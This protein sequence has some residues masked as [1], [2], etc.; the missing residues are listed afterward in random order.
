M[1]S[2]EES[3]VSRRRYDRALTARAE[4]E[5]LLEAKSRELYEANVELKKQAQF[6]EDRVAARTK[7]LRSLLA[8]AESANAAKSSFLAMMS[9]ELR[10]P[11]NGVLGIA[12][13]LEESDLDEEQLFLLKTL[14]NSGEQLLRLLNDV[15]DLSK[16]E[17]GKIELELRDLDVRQL[18]SEILVP[19]EEIAQSKGININMDC[20]NTVPQLLNAD[21]HRLRQI[22]D[23]FMSNAIK[24][25][26]VGTVTLSV[27]R[28]VE[29]RGRD[30][31]EVSVQDTGIGITPEQMDR[32]FTPFTQADSSTSRKFGGTGLGLV[33]ARNLCRLMGGDV[34]VQS[35][36]GQGTCFKF[37]IDALGSKAQSERDDT[38]MLKQSGK[39]PHWNG[40]LNVLMAEDNKTNQVVMKALMKAVPMKLNIVEN[41]RLAVDAVLKEQFDVV[42]M[43]INMPTMDGLEA[44][45]RIRSAEKQNQTV[46]VPIIAL[47]ANAMR[48]QQEEY[49][50]I[51]M[52]DCVTKPVRKDELLMTVTSVLKRYSHPALNAA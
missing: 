43:D 7:E 35:A 38:Q 46:R 37:W 44:T 8:T 47:T 28:R 41:G 48:D 49:K 19:H 20:G 30:V 14:S 31:I 9:H 10:T 23:N 25:T 52:D 50:R 15:L 5:E 4:A 39:A 2:T 40:V 33:I 32:L 3:K 45:R 12:Q 1:T 27:Q 18:L 29:L 13:A 22:I 16:I 17:A 6:L 21:G 51:G 26:D 24:F 11:L 36:P 42:L 34:S